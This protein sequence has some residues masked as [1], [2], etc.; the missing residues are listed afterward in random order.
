MTCVASA[1]LTKLADMTT[2][3]DNTGGWTSEGAAL[4][5]SMTGTV[6]T[7]NGSGSIRGI[8][9]NDT[10]VVSSMT[11]KINAGSGY[12]TIAAWINAADTTENSI[13]SY[14]GQDNGFKFALKDG[15]LQLT[16][17]SVV[18][19]NITSTS[20]STNTWTLV[21]IS[22]ALDT[23]SA[24]SFF[25][26]SNEAATEVCGGWNEARPAT[27]GIGTG[28]S[29]S[30]RDNFKGSIANL[31]VFWSEA[32]ATSAEINAVMGSAPVA[33]PEPA[34]ATLSLLALAGLAA[35][36]RRQ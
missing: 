24:S 32:A 3:M 33:V 26:N 18:D 19:K 30:E 5:T 2:L 21:G 22:F 34:A 12:L 17:K 4:D 13:F 1:E 11:E 36:R 14:G 15:H 35:R 23:T 25:V 29:N 10:A 27:F 16:T 8:G 7:F 6:Y 28:N 31:T 9:N 20:V